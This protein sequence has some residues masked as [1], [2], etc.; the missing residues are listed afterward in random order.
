MPRLLLFPRVNGAAAE[1]RFKKRYTGYTR[2]ALVRV[3]IAA[4]LPSYPVTHQSVTTHCLCHHGL[5]TAEG[6][7]SDRLLNE[8]DAGR[9]NAGLNQ[10]S[11]GKN[12][13]LSHPW[14]AWHLG[15]SDLETLVCIS[16]FLVRAAADELTT[17]HP[18]DVILSTHCVNSTREMR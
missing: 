8:D 4:S 7:S 17:S 5:S 10:T 15:D 6:R 2:Y 9:E 14:P 16:G 1:G 12:F 11:G 18:V 3:H 13:S